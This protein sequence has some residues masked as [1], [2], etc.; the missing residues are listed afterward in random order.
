MPGIMKNA[1][2]N[3]ILDDK[4]ILNTTVTFTGF[5]K[6]KFAQEPYHTDT[7]QQYIKY[8]TDT[9]QKANFTYD[10]LDSFAVY[11]ENGETK[12]YPF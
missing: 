2:V 12:L 8:V 5:K 3:F 10:K 9:L 7:K 4:G 11:Q 6:E 1:N